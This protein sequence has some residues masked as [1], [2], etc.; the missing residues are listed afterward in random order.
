VTVGTWVFSQLKALARGIGIYD[1]LQPTGRQLLTGLF[2]GVMGQG[3]LT[4]TR[5][6]LELYV[7]NP[8][9]RALVSKISQA[10]ASVEWNCYAPARRG[11]MRTV[12]DAAVRLQRS[13]DVRLRTKGL[14]QMMASG[15]LEKLDSHPMIGLLER[16]CAALPGVAVQRLVSTYLELAGESFLMIERDRANIPTALWPIPP[17][18]VQS[19]PS[20]SRPVYRLAYKA[21]QAEIPESEILWLK[22]PTPTDPYSRGSGTV[23]A[24]GTELETDEAAATTALSW[25]RNQARPDSLVVVEGASREELERLQVDWN[26]K[27]RGVFRVF[28]SHFLN[29]KIDVQVLDSGDFRRQQL[30]GQREHM[31]RVVQECF[32]IP[33][34]LLG[35]LSSSNRATISAAETL[36]SRH[37]IIPRLELLRSYYQRLCAEFD[38][39]LILTYTSP[40]PEDEE[41]ALSVM[42]SCPS[43]FSLDEYR[44]R[45]GYGALPNGAGEVLATGSPQ[46]LTTAP[47]RSVPAWDLKKLNEAQLRALHTLASKAQGGAP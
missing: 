5:P 22:D 34:E 9:A 19:I 13:P 41:Y 3:P 8:L 29:A 16:G 10:V 15:Q 25:F 37:C 27:N 32:G 31:A 47:V 39:R 33:P 40:V 28:K 18:W 38:D 43:A 1:D 20:P 21:L 26:A 36:F 14:D 7:S 17:T 44:A 2:P 45:A 35:R 24:L 4:S 46:S 12:S 42:R 30:V 23:R 11:G 6:A